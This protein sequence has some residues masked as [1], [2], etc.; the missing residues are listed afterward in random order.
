MASA[1]YMREYF[2]NNPWIQVL[3]WAR[4]RC[5]N[6]HHSKFRWYG[7]KGI[8]CLLT[9]EDVKELWFRDHAYAMM[10]PSLDR[11]KT[12]KDYT[13]DNCRFIELNKNR[14]TSIFKLGHPSY[15]K[16]K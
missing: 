3:N 14:A 5:N 2:K 16:E 11:K 4:R 13:L 6:P 9:K 8:K 7:G 12:D 1:E 15:H 10:Q